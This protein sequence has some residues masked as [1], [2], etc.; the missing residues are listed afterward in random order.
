MNLLHYF[1]DMLN[2]DRVEGKVFA[3]YRI[4][5]STRPS[6]QVGKMNIILR[7]V[8]DLIIPF[9]LAAVVIMDTCCVTALLGLRSS[10]GAGKRI[11]PAI[12]S[13]GNQCITRKERSKGRQACTNDSKAVFDR[14]PGKVTACAN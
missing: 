7:S 13:R 14:S 5:A 10:R 11:I 8:L 6:H 4:I 1:S 2:F 12:Q 9:E 3:S